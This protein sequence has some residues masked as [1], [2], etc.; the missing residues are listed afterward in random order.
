MPRFLALLTACFSLALASPARAG[1]DATAAARTALAEKADAP[2]ELPELPSLAADRAVLA[3]EDVAHGSKGEAARAAHAAAGNAGRSAEARA[4][5][6][7]RA[8]QKAAAKA[9][10]DEARAAAAQARTERVKKGKKEK[11]GDGS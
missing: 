1:E 10:R 9:A 7:S 4:A 2:E 11:P 8:A 3:Q 6:A 5:A